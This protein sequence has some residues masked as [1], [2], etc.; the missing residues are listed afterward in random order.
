[1]VVVGTTDD[2]KPVVKSKKGNLTVDVDGG[3]TTNMVKPDNV[4]IKG[5]PNKCRKKSFRPRFSNIIAETWGEYGLKQ[6]PVVGAV[7][8]AGMA[9]WRLFQGDNWCRY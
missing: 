3:A 5:Y 6:L 7:A 2:G 8:G 4:K 1:M 9:M